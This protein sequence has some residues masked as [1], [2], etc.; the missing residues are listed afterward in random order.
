MITENFDEDVVE[1]EVESSDSPCLLE[2][3]FQTISEE[4]KM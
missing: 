4:S 1:K 2:K 3:A